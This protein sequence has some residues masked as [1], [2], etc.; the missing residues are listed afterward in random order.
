[1]KETA[2]FFYYV[3]NLFGAMAHLAKLARMLVSHLHVSREPLRTPS[4]LKPTET[5]LHSLL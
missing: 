5:C 1:M 3:W 2:C 4:K